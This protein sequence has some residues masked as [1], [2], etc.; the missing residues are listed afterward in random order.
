MI[1]EQVA[2][3]DMTSTRTLENSSDRSFCS[4]EEA[5]ILP[6]V[7]IGRGAELRRVVIDKGSRI[8]PGLRAGFDP[9]EDRKRFYVTDKG[10]TLITAEMPDQNLH[11]TR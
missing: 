2:R 5:V 4:I 6:N 3:A 10:I 9:E 1:D 8:P 7:Q 11:R